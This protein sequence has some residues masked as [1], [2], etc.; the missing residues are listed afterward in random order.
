MLI[1]AKTKSPTLRTFL[2]FCLLQNVSRSL[3]VNKHT[4]YIESI[5]IYTQIHNVCVDVCMDVCMEKNTKI[6][7][8]SQT[9]QLMSVDAHLMSV[10]YIVSYIYIYID[11]IPS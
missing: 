9:C 6:H 3:Y 8:N 10:S 11:D 5:Y 1:F 7:R 4:S 2:G